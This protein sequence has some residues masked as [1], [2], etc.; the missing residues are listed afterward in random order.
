MENLVRSKIEKQWEITI[1]K[2]NK[3]YCFY[4][5]NNI[6]DKNEKG[7]TNF[8]GLYSHNENIIFLTLQ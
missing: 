7:N 6:I 5:L 8:F 3:G 4:I 1:I 2:T